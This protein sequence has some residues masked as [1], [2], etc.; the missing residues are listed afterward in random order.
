M[1]RRGIEKVDKKFE[2]K[3]CLFFF[4]IF[5]ATVFVEVHVLQW[6][7]GSSMDGDAPL[8]IFFSDFLR[9]RLC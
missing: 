9:Y 8:F 4:P 7:K 2:K 3:N 5:Y 6:S 1:R